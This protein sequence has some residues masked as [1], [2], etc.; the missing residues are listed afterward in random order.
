VLRAVRAVIDAARGNRRDAAEEQA[1][2][3]P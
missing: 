1:E 2:W 3:R